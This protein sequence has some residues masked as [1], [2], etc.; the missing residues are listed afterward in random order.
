M[1]KLFIF[2]ISLLIS[3]TATCMDIFEAIKEGNLGRV[4]KLINENPEVVNAHERKYKN[5][6]LHYAALCGK[7]DIATLLLCN[8]ADVNSQAARNNTP[9]HHACSCDHIHVAQILIDYGAN[10]F[11]CNKS[12]STPLHTASAKGYTHAV[13]FLLDHDAQIDACDSGNCTPL[14]D[15]ARLGHA[16]VSAV[17]LNRGADIN[18]HNWQNKTPLESAKQENYINVIQLF[19]D[20]PFYFLVKKREQKKRKESILAFCMAQHPRCGADSLA[21]N[22]PIDVFRWIGKMV[23]MPEHTPN[24]IHQIANQERERQHQNNS[25]CSIQ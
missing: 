17:L 20:W 5:T 6:P 23:S 13:R 9:L 18:A 19:E 2:T 12:R 7:A 11:G 15:A 8:N 1:K 16:H 14:H 21:H 10:V 22:L 24:Q 25:W 3:Q 4:Q